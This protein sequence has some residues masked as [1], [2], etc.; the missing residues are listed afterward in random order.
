MMV[1]R[2]LVLDSRAQTRAKASNMAR[3]SLRPGRAHRRMLMLMVNLVDGVGLCRTQTCYA[4]PAAVTT[5]ICGGGGAEGEYN[6]GWLQERK[7]R[8]VGRGSRGL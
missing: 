1:S 6:T 7:K 5:V 3:T 4:G 2:V 8:G